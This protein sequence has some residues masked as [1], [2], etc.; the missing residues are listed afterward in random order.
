[1]IKQMPVSQKVLA[2]ITVFLILRVGYAF[3]HYRQLVNASIGIAYYNQGHYKKAVPRLQALRGLEP[4]NPRL[5]ADLGYSFFQIKDYSGAI[6]AYKT[7]IKA[8]AAYYDDFYYFGLCLSAAGYRNEAVSAWQEGLGRAKQAHRTEISDK[9]PGSSTRLAYIKSV[10]HCLSAN[11]NAD[12]GR[13]L[14][15]TPGVNVRN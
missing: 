14:Q 2:L 10:E 3:Y 7:L 9:M 8:N 11:I 15:P 1:M 12:R 6:A 13:T 5:N 4:T